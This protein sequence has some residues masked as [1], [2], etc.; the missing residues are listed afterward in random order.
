M[1]TFGFLT[2]L[3]EDHLVNDTDND[4][5]TDADV[6]LLCDDLESACE[7]FGREY[8]FRLDV[9]YPADKPRVMILSAH[10]IRL[11]LEERQSAHPESVEPRSPVIVQRIADA[12]WG[13]GRAG[14]QYRDLIPGRLGGKYIASHIRILQGGPVPDYVHHHDVR[15]QLIYC[16]KGWVTLVYEDQG[17]PFTM[18]AGDCVLQPPHI[19]HR[20][21]ESSDALEVIEFACP[22]E[23]ETCVDHDMQLPTGSV[24]PDRKFDGQTFV[25]HRGVKGDWQ[26]AALAGFKSLDTGICAA[27]RG[28]VSANVLRATSEIESASM[29]STTELCCNF[30]LAGSAT[31]SCYGGETECLRSGTSF[32]VPRGAAIDLCAVSGDFG[33]LQVRS[34]AS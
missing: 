18:S 19:R 28:I 26:A 16:L 6:T 3:C 14:M 12:A 29:K 8:G 4:G 7:S 30:V 23:H 20:V 10:D 31:M 25:L 22:A 15:F 13:D 17:P 5:T 33:M 34:P 11:R 9:V 32:T 27:T 2:C 24:R 1:A 21:L